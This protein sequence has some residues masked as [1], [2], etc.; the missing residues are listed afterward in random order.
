MMIKILKNS[1]IDISQRKAEYDAIKYMS[2]YINNN[3]CILVDMKINYYSNIIKK[4]Y[5]PRLNDF[6]YQRYISLV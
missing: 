4:E 1:L 5:L 2:K 3:N 6:H